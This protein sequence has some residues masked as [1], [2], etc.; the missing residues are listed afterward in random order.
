MNGHAF[1]VVALCT[2]FLLYVL[3]LPVISAETSN[4]QQAA[5]ENTNPQTEV[6]PSPSDPTMTVEI[7]ALPF[8]RAKSSVSVK[9][10]NVEIG[11]LSSKDAIDQLF[12]KKMWHKGYI[13]FNM[14]FENTGHYPIEVSTGNI[15]LLDET[16]DITE[17]KA[18][19]KKLTATP[20]EAE[21]TEKKNKKKKT[22]KRNKKSEITWY[23]APVPPGVV[24]EK[25]KHVQYGW[26]GNLGMVLLTGA[27]LG[28]AAPLTVPAL[29]VG[30][31]YRGSNKRMAT[32]FQDQS[33]ERITVDPGETVETWLFYPR[34]KEQRSVPPKKII[35]ADIYIPE[36]EELSQFVIDYQPQKMNREAVRRELD[37]IEVASLKVLLGK[38]S[39]GDKHLLED[40]SEDK[41]ETLLNDGVDEEPVSIPLDKEQSEGEE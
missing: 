4:T 19:L 16:L 9:S 15:L 39:P 32:N 40:A 37:N 26:K 28:L 35:F 1:V 29:V 18:A 21:S 34:D 23:T 31:A 2:M 20:D 25:T 14:A 13:P 36:Q 30:N 24:F 27:T 5:T 8:Q 17:V 11:Y 12:N 38:V 6:V 7:T 33:L 10:L 41:I 22:K 3:P